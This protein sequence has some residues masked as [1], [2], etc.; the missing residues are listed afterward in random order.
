MQVELY[1]YLYLLQRVEHTDVSRH[2][3]GA[4]SFGVTKGSVESEHRELRG[5]LVGRF[6]THKSPPP[7]RVVRVHRDSP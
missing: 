5:F 2:D 6:A 7:R 1:L 4:T 3:S